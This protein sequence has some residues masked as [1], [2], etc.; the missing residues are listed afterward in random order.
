MVKY[1][2]YMVFIKQ[3]F[4]K[5]I[6]YK[7]MPNFNSVPLIWVHLALTMVVLEEPTL[8]CISK[9]MYVALLLIK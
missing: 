5:M 3:V 2:E 1:E 9:N 4:L 8:L 7:V 6:A